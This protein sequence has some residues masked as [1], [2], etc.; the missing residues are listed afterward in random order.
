MKDLLS[1][2][3]KDALVK[4]ELRHAATGQDMWAGFHWDQDSKR[5]VVSVMGHVVGEFKTTK[6]VREFCVMH[7]R[8]F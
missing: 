8:E 1:D 3:C 7:N 6:A 2:Y 5:H 4:A